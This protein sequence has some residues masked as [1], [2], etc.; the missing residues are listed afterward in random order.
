[1][2]DRGWPVNRAVDGTPWLLGPEEFVTY[3]D[4][5]LVEAKVKW[6]GDNAFG[7]V[8]CWEL[9]Q[10]SAEGTLLKALPQI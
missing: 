4:A 9:G 7:G 10:D 3:E 8:F 5:A 2:L 1:M 6:V